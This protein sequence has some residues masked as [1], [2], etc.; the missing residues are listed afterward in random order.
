M[1]AGCKCG[2][3]AA[4]REVAAAVLCLRALYICSLLEAEV[5]AEAAP[6]GEA[7]VVLLPG[8]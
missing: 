2:A 8:S 1:L 3:G 4:P 7:I 6:E 5:D